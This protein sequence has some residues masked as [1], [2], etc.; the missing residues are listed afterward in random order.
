M[1][2]IIILGLMSDVGGNNT[3][4]EYPNLLEDKNVR[5]KTDYR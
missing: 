5:Q 2:N 3:Y 4:A 1:V